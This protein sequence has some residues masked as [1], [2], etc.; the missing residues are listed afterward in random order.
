MRSRK[1]IEKE[2]SV[3]Q[4]ETLGMLSEKVYLPV[5][6]EVLLDVRELLEDQKRAASTW[7]GADRKK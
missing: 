1:E 6:L 7:V 2:L 3:K 4:A 5:L